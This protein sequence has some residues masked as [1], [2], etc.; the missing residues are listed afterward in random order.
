MQGEKGAR[1]EAPAP[2]CGCPGEEREGGGSDQWGHMRPMVGGYGG[3]DIYSGE[4][5]ALNF[6]TGE[7]WRPPFSPCPWKSRLSPLFCV[8]TSNVK[9]VQNFILRKEFHKWPA[10][11]PHSMAQWGSC[12]QQRV[13]FLLGCRQHTTLALPPSSPGAQNSQ[14]TRRSSV[15]SMSFQLPL[16]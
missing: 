4:V 15:H 14:I 16:E 1:A 7:T 8:K 2:L 10:L 3:L 11:W 13:T 9:T 6:L 5:G 12:E